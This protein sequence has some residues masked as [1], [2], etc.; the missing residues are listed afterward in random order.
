M[1][2]DS[3]SRYVENQGILSNVND[4]ELRHKTFK[5]IHPDEWLDNK[6]AWL[7]NFDIDAVMAQYEDL[8]KDFVFLGPVPIDFEDIYTE[9]SGK[10]LQNLYKQGKRRIGIVFNLDPHWKDV[11]ILI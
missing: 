2:K 8:Y 9:L 5:P 3:C 1:L 10:T 4:D 7:S 6:Y 11:C